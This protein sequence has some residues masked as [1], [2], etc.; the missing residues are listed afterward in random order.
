DEDR[1]SPRDHF[2][3]RPRMLQDEKGPLHS[4]FQLLDELWTAATKQERGSSVAMKNHD[5]VGFDL[6]NFELPRNPQ[7]LFLKLVN[8]TDNGAPCCCCCSLEILVAY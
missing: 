2:R 4:L 3:V 5:I 6:I 1:A 7:V 8:V